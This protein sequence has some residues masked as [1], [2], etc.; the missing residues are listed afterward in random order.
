MCTAVHHSDISN[1]SVGRFAGSGIGNMGPGLAVHPDTASVMSFNSA[2]TSSTQAKAARSTNHQLGT[3][4]SAIHISP[5]AQHH[6]SYSYV[7]QLCTVLILQD[8]TRV[9]IFAHTF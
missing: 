1:Y 9:K 3:K 5:A 8:N 2:H 7:L 6:S 4:V